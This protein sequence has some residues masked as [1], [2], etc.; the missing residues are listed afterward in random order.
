MLRIVTI[1]TLITGIAETYPTYP[2]GYEKVQWSI[3]RGQKGTEDVQNQNGDPVKTSPWVF[4]TPWRLRQK[5]RRELKEVSDVA[6]G[7]F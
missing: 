6:N 4:T 2:P 7:K 3:G 1:N 5:V